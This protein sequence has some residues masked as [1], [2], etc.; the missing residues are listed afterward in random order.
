QQALLLNA[1]VPGGRLICAPTG[2][3]QR[4]ID[5]VRRFFDAAAEA[6]VIAKA[7]GAKR[8]V[9]IPFGIPAR[10]AERYQQAAAAAFFG[11]AQALH[12]PLEGREAVGEET[13][14]PIQTVG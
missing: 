2:P 5:D 6:A 4:D 1:E 9:I 10:V 13:L 3:L 11:F 14:E 8:P 7:A 12:E